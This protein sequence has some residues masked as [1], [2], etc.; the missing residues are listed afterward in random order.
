MPMTTVQ[1]KERQGRRSSQQT[2]NGRRTSGEVTGPPD[3][4][5]LIALLIRVPSRWWPALLR[6]SDLILIVV[7]FVMAYWVRYRLQWFLTVDPANQTGLVT[8]M[9][10]GLALVFLLFCSFQFSRVYVYRRDRL[11]IE[12]VYAIASATTIGVVVLII[13]NLAFGQLSFSRLIFLYS[14]VL[15]T[16]LLGISR[17]VIYTVRGY[18]RNQGIGLERVV[19]VGAG[20]VGLMVMRTIA[21]RPSLGYELVGFLDDDPDINQTDIGRFQALGPLT[22]FFDI[23][24]NSDIDTAVICLPWR[25]HRIVARLLHLCE[26]NGVTAQIVPDFFQLTKNQMQVERLDGI[27]LITTRAVSIAGWNL[28]VKRG[29]DVTLATVM[30]VLGLP[31]AALIALCVRLSSPGS[32]IYSQTRVGRNGRQFKIYKFRSMI[33]DADTQLDEIA[34]LNEASG[35]LF[36]MRDDPRRTAVGGIL[37]RLSLD[38]L[39]NLLNVLRGEMSLVGPRPNV[40]E[41]VAQYKDWHR[42]R[43]SVS[44]GMTGLWQVSGRSDLTFDEMVLLDIYYAENWS[45]TLDLSILLRTIPKVL[46]GEGA[47]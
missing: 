41:E 5:W 27:P 43:L 30:L 2:L 40:P 9:P 29:L 17:A 44:P 45:L 22:N 11:W 15:V 18:L 31:L 14:A 4:S 12:E 38:E 7:A 37:R 47:Y 35:P 32:V 10:F 20:D 21:A 8:Y 34:D 1:M 42:K 23:L 36:K 24:Q 19:L 25:S 16:L 46:G 33:A 3:R 26:Q 28:F 13:L 6:I 39:P